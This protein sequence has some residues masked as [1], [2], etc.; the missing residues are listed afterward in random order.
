MMPGNT[1]YD[2]SVRLLARFP[3]TTSSNLNSDKNLIEWW[4]QL[5]R[6]VGFATELKFSCRTM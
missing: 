1:I 5:C 6:M 3:I 4:E 2:I